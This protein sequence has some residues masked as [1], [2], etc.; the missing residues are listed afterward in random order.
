MLNDRHNRSSFNLFYRNCA[1]FSRMLFRAAYPGS[2]PRNAMADFF[3]TTPKHLAKSITRYGEAKPEVEFATFQIPQVE[4][5][6]RRSHT[7]KGIAESLVRSKKYFVPLA[8][9][10]PTT[11]ASL[12]AA[13][14]GTGRFVVP[15]NAPVM[16]EL[17]PEPVGISLS[18]LAVPG[19]LAA[20]PPLACSPIEESTTLDAMATGAGQQ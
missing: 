18:G 13:Y 11:A 3:L 5:T 19:E 14:V 17:A 16:P 8:F 9:L 2:I 15:K 4:G 12:V 1:D 10:S 20:A 6:I 7:V